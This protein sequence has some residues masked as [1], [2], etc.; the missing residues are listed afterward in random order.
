MLFVLYIQ[1]GFV[2]G[3]F[4]SQW[5]SL[6]IH[7]RPSRKGA[8]S[9]SCLV[10]LSHSPSNHSIHKLFLNREE[11]RTREREKKEGERRERGKEAELCVQDSSLQLCQSLAICL[12][13]IPLCCPRRCFL[14]AQGQ[15]KAGKLHTD[16]S[17][18]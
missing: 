11:E 7:Q 4:V 13:S 12:L 5:G 2:L 14:T 16:F 18:G 15:A 17:R 10:Q 9:V 6:G 8:R 1:L 3:Y